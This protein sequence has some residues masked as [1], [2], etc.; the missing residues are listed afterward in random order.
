MNDPAIR[1]LRKRPDLSNKRVRMTVKIG[2]VATSSATFEAS[3]NPSALF[4]VRK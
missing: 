1:L 3:V 2:A 4:S